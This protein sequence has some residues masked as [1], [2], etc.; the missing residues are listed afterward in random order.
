MLQ[1]H[2][3]EVTALAFS[4]RGRF[5]VTASLDTTLGGLGSL[6]GKLR[7]TLQGHPES[8]TAV[9]IAPAASNS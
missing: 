8:A 6:S 5:L 1:G 9:A 7:A 2:N 4:P 3:D